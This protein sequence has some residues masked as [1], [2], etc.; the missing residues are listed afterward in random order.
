MNLLSVPSGLGFD[1]FKSDEDEDILPEVKKAAALEAADCVLTGVFSV[2]EA[3]CNGGGGW[4][5]LDEGWCWSGSGFLLTTS[6]TG[7]T[8]CDDD[9]WELEV[10]QL[11]EVVSSWTLLIEAPTERKNQS[12]HLSRKTL[13]IFFKFKIKY[14]FAGGILKNSSDK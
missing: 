12:F 3:S 11:V 2:A 1:F 13:I 10:E 4:F 7:G 14:Q 8:G 6:F 9:W 5:S